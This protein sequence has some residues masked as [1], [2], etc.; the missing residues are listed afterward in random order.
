[1]DFLSE[2][3]TTWNDHWGAGVASIAAL[4]LVAI[5]LAEKTRNLV[6]GFSRWVGWRNIVRWCGSM[7]NRVSNVQ[8]QACHAF[9]V[10]CDGIAVPY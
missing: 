5:S 4:V 7:Q 3:W 8:S 1:M 2:L 10:G 6:S 9:K